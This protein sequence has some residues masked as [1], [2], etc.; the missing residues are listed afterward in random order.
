VYC[1]RCGHLLVERLLLTEDRPRLVCAACGYIHY[2]NPKIV[3]GTLPVWDGQVW[4]LR[5][6]HAVGHSRDVRWPSGCSSSTRM[7]TAGIRRQPSCTNLRD[8][9]PVVTCLASTR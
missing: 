1:L 4:L 5:R 7:A 6:A 9:S 3:C 2:V 8:F